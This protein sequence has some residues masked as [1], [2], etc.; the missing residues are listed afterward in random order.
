MSKNILFV[1]PYRQDDGWGEAAADYAKALAT[2]D[3]NIAIRPIYMGQS[4]VDLKDETLLELEGNRFPYYD[5]VI[6]KVLPHLFEKREMLTV[7]LFTL[8]TSEIETTPWKEHIFNM[9][10]VMTP[11]VHEKNIL[12]HK[13]MGYNEGYA[14]SEPVDITK[15]DKE[16]NKLPHIPTDTFNFYFIGEY[17]ERKNLDA[18]IVAFHREFDRREPVNLI[19]KTNSGGM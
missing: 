15:F 16:H 5:I 11:S 3:N 10:M 1:G 9:D 18:L 19:I 12:C 14:I 17:I 8:E 6:E 2:T 4:V 13:R 7:G